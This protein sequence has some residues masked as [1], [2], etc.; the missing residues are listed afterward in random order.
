MYVIAWRNTG[1]WNLAC[2]KAMKGL[3]RD[4]TCSD[5]VLATIIRSCVGR[6]IDSFT[7]DH[8]QHCLEHGLAGLG[9]QSE[10][11]AAPSAQGS[12]HA[13]LAEKGGTTLRTVHVGQ[14]RLTGGGV[15]PGIK[16]GRRMTTCQGEKF[17]A[18]FD[19][20]AGPDYGVH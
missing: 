7:L 6:I 16:A 8:M 17:G 11:A 14:R 19:A 18:S 9:M 3:A 15:Q 4:A 13:P 1:Y 12:N 20:Q 2:C 10:L 5:W